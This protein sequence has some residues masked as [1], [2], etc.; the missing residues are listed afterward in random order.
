MNTY[1]LVKYYADLLIIQYI[2]KVKA[3]ATI[4]AQVTPV[5]MPQTTVDTIS[6]S[7]A[8]DAGQFVLSYNGVSTPPI[9]W[10][11]SASVIQGY[12]RSLAPNTID[13]GDAFTSVFDEDIDGGD[14]TTVSFDEEIDGGDAEGWDLLSEI[15][16]T[17]SIA[18]GLTITFEGVTPVAEPLELVSSTLTSGGDP[19]TVT[20]TEVDETLPVAV[21]NAFNLTGDNPAQGVQLHVI[22]KYAGVTRS[23]NGFTGPI[24]LDDTDFMTLI[25]MAI[26]QNNAGSSLADIQN[27]LNRYFPGKILVFDYANMRLSYLISYTLGSLD[28][29]QLFV[30]EKLLPRPM[31]VEIASIIYVPSILNL[32]SFRTYS[33]PSTNGKGFNTYSDYQTDWPWLTYA[34]A[35]VI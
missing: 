22:G 1:E 5:I 17:G 10:D 24:T 7:P 31:A 29:I 25:Q 28:L 3:Y 33:L 9:N 2:G 21:Q 8:P 20:I 34:D 26:I 16:V 19:V 32:F 4:K 15:I 11:D 35:V 30:T 27:L 13:G 12:L 6:F 14:A 18:T 23:G